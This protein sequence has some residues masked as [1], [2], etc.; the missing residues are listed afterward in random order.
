[1][2]VQLVLDQGFVDHFGEGLTERVEG[3]FKY[4]RMYMGQQNTLG[5][6]FDLN[7]LP[8]QQ[9]YQHI[10]ETTAENLEYVFH[11]YI[12]HEQGVS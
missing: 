12:R 11:W 9:I 3:I 2:T 7:V 8:Y 1:M 10:N 5:V 6:K 4:L